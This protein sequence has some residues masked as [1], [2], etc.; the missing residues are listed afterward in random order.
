[1]TLCQILVRPRPPLEISDH[2]EMCKYV[3]MKCSMNKLIEV[4][5]ALGIVRVL[6][7]VFFD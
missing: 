2:H 5:Y 1:M 6:K 7:F 3:N 4:V